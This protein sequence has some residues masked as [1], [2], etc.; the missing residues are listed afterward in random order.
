MAKGQA[1]AKQTRS[2]APP[3]ARKGSA[4]KAKAPRKQAA[5]RERKATKARKR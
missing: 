1:V 3:A 4:K 2:A 5:A